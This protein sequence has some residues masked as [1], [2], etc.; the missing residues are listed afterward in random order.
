MSF[1]NGYENYEKI[2]PTYEEERDISF[3]KWAPFD[4]RKKPYP[5]WDPSSHNYQNFAA[6][7]TAPPKYANPH[8]AYYDDGTGVPPITQNNMTVQDIY[9][10]PFLFLQAHHKNYSNVAVT[11]LK[12]IQTESELS[13]LFFS[14][15]NFKRIQKSIKK[16]VFVR[17]GGQFKL[18][19]DQEQRDVFIAMRAVY[20]EHA[21]FL[22]GQIVRQVKRLNQKVISEILPGIIT[23]IRQYY[24]Y[25]KEI[26]KPLDPIPRPLNMSNA[27]RRTLPSITTTWGIN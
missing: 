10:T 11:A 4:Q 23:E 16:A 19:V 26:N 22:P 3:D 2:S 6:F 13:K 8:D 12:G 25:L 24:G 20:M 18:D 27:G 17:T 14:D 9:R 1:T 15:E 5:T 7:T 21:R